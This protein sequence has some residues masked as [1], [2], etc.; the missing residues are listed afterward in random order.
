MSCIGISTKLENSSD[1]LNCGNAVIQNMSENMQFSCF[2]VL[3]GSAEA[4]V[5]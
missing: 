4:L 5:K 2:P 3:P 1:W